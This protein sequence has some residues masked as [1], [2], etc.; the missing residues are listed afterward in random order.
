MEINGLKC[1]FEI[2]MIP[3][4]KKQKKKQKQTKTN[5]QTKNPRNKTIKSYYHG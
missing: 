2:S 5:R 3:K 1:G 4:N